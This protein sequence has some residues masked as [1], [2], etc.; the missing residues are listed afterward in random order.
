ML[1]QTC[2]ATGCGREQAALFFEKDHRTANST[3]KHNDKN[4]NVTPEIL[5]FL[6]FIYC[7]IDFICILRILMTLLLKHQLQF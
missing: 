3:E 2:D 7:Q 4:K 6:G 1:V 5:H